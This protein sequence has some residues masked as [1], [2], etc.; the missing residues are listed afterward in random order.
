MHRAWPGEPFLGE[1]PAALEGMNLLS[2]P[3]GAVL[4]KNEPQRGGG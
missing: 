3:I 4:G 2:Q 1:G